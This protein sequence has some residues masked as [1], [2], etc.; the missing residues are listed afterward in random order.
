MFGDPY[1]YRTTTLTFE[2]VGFK[3][4]YHD[5]MGRPWYENFMAIP[6]CTYLKLKLS[7]PHGVITIV[8]LFGHAYE[9]AVE[10]Y[11]LTLEII[12]SKELTII[13]EQLV[14]NAPNS[15]KSARS[16]N[17]R[18]TSKKSSLTMKTPTK[19]WCASAHRFSTSAPVNF[20]YVNKDIFVW[21][22]SNML[23]ILREVVEHSLKIRVDS[24]P[25]KE[26]MHHFNEEKYRAISEDIT[27][28]LVARFIKEVYHPNWLANLVV[29]QKMNV[30]W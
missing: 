27:K 5:I 2:V 13:R 25:V 17:Q 8:S 14:E 12:T 26:L 9:C 6:N 29:V 7:G 19:R 16:F 28:L 3:R 4:S 15:M 30:K 24:K 21:K 22:P 10:S 1:N 20:L 18:R 11:E 23:G